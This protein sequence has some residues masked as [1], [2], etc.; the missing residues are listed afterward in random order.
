MG[1]AATNHWSCGVNGPQQ[2]M[3]HWGK[4]GEQWWGQALAEDNVCGNRQGEN[5]VHTNQTY[6]VLSGLDFRNPK[7]KLHLL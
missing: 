7:Q 5:T 4:L 1:M 2:Q 3:G 6:F